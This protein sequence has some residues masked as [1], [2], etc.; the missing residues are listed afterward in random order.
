M[1]CIERKEKVIEA[2]I[3]CSNERSIR[4]F[5]KAGYLES[6]DANNDCS[7]CIILRYKHEFELNGR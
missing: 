2:H 1:Y 4:A 5:I 3:K 6:E 7:D